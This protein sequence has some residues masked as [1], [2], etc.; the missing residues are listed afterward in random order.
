LIACTVGLSVS[1]KRPICQIS[2]VVAFTLCVTT[3][4]VAG[5]QL[6]LVGASVSYYCSA[7]LFRS[8]GQRRLQGVG[9]VFVLCLL[10]LTPF[11]NPYMVVLGLIVA[12][13]CLL[14]IGRAPGRSRGLIVPGVA[15]VL[16]SLKLFGLEVILHGIVALTPM[17]ALGLY[18]Y[19]ARCWEIGFGF[20]ALFILFLFII[21]YSDNIYVLIGVL[22]AAPLSLLLTA[23]PR[24]CLPPWLL[25][26]AMLI[27]VPCTL[28]FY[29]HDSL[30]LAYCGII[31]GAVAIRAVGRVALIILVPAA[32]GFAC[33][34]DFLMQRRRTAMGWAIALVCLGE[35]GV[36]TKTF[37]AAENRALIERLRGQVDRGRVAFYYH[38]IDDLPFYRH[39]LDAMWASLAS[40]V[41]TVNGYSGHTPRSWHRFFHADVNPHADVANALADWELSHGLLPRHVQWIRSGPLGM[42]QSLAEGAS[43][44]GVPT[45]QPER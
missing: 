20:L 21:V 15:L 39:H 26:R 6:A 8:V 13:F 11:P 2:A 5:N 24:Y 36:T 44:G 25:L 30:W 41:P 31:P 40:G 17:A 7:G 43:L 19:R 35:Q 1:W 38:P 27:A 32:V 29:G 22:V 9:L 12:V 4:Y 33:L 42:S 37:S 45:A 14:E 10:L 28:L 18:Y 34:V 16:V 3:T 23:S